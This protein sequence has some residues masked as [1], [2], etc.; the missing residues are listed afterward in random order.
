MDEPTDIDMPDGN[1]YGI[2]Q[3]D[4]Y[5]RFNHVTQKHEIVIQESVFKYD[6]TGVHLKEC[7]TNEIVLDYD[8]NDKTIFE[9]K[10]K[11]RTEPDFPDHP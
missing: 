2:L 7:Y 3:G 9:F 5:L 4:A 6:S 10:L 8:A 11:G 1:K